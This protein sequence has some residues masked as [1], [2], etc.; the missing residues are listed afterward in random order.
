MPQICKRKPITNIWLMT[1]LKWKNRVGYI[2]WR[3]LHVEGASVA[4]YPDMYVELGR[5]SA[6]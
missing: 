6:L 5:P 2:L 1:H 3:V 4:I